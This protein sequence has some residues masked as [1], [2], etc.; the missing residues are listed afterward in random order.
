M[1][2][3][4]ALVASDQR[5]RHVHKRL[6]VHLRY[7]SNFV[8]SLV[9][10]SGSGAVLRLPKIAHP[11]EGTLDQSVQLACSAVAGLVQCRCPTCEHDRLAAFRD[12]LPSHSA[13]RHCHPS[14]RFL[15][16]QVD[17]HWSDVIADS[18]QGT[19]HYAT[20]LSGQ[21]CVT[22]ENVTPTMVIVEPAMVVIIPRASS[23]PAPNSRSHY[24]SNR[25][26]TAEPA[27]IQTAASLNSRLNV[28]RV[29]MNRLSC[30]SSL[31]SADKLSTF[32]GQFQ[33]IHPS[34]H[35]SVCLSVWFLTNT[36]V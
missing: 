20:Y 32:R 2:R 15:I 35:L 1:Q 22:I 9:A 28:R 18:V 17:L 25:S 30:Q 36:L 33:T 8:Q 23:A 26:L 12:R 31:T 4:Q 21:R 11:P 3:Q 16:V 24:A 6:R 5:T 10:P 14:C 13:R 27:S 19:L 34:I 7:R 29:S